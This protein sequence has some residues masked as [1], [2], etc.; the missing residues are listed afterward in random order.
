MV[1]EEARRTLL[2]ER[3]PDGK[4]LGDRLRVTNAHREWLKLW[5][6]AACDMSE[7]EALE[8]R[9]KK[10]QAAATARR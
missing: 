7:E 6:I 10:P 3:T 8:W 5:T 2:R 4:A 9:G 1:R